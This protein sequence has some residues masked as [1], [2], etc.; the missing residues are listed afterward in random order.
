MKQKR[1]LWIVLI[2]VFA[3]L[4]VSQVAFALYCPTP[5]AYCCKKRTIVPWSTM[6]KCSSYHQWTLHRGIL[7]Y[8]YARACPF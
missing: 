3:L 8:C 4:L 6:F 1:F 7:K 5:G 2:L